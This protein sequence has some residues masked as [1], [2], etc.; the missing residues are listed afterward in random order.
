MGLFDRFRKRV[1]EVAEEAD[2]DALSVEA[3]SDEA[4]AL[5]EQPPEQP[6]DSIQ[7]DDWDDVDEG[8]PQTASVEDDDD[9]WDTWDDDEPV[10]P[11]SLTKRERKLLER[12]EKER[13]KREE[14]VKKAMKKRGAVDVARPQGSKV[15]LSMMRTTTGRQLVQV[16]QAPKGSSK[17]AAIHLE[18]GQTI[19]VDLGGGV[20]SEGGRVIKPGEALDNLLEELEWVLLESDISSQASSAIIDSLRNALIGARLRRGAELS[21]VLEAALKRALHAL[22][23][24]GYWDFD[25]TV[26]GFI[27][28]G[29][30]PVVIMLVGVNGTGKTTTA[31]ALAAAA[32]DGTEARG[33]SASSERGRSKQTIPLQP[34]SCF[35]INICLFIFYL[36]V[37]APPIK[38]VMK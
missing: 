26:D 33:G 22:L 30:V 28:A 11:V 16:A 12:Q 13:R 23:Q 37:L 17:T 15:D 19:D 29:D 3:T 24:A 14:K 35:N 4:Q 9:D 32:E 6:S 38:R 36:F 27:E 18:G 1:H 2:G 10:A 25:A 5:L 7:D 21:K 31:A 8:P 20:V 34:I